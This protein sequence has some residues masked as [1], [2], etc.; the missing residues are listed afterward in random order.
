MKNSEGVVISTLEQASAAASGKF[1]YDPDTKA[2]TF[3]GI[4]DGTEIVVPYKRKIHANVLTNESDVY[5][6][7]C[8]LYIDAFA[9]DKCARVYRVQ[10]YIPKADF[11]G[12]FTF[13]M[14]DS[15]IVHSFEAEAQSGSCG[16]G[17]QLWTYTIF[18]V[19]EADVTGD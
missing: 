6:S 13:E 3:S 17:G 8:A 7:K 18:G 5:S 14:S 15:Q 16:T 11:N 10:F 19:D 9:E 12:E 1:A 4:A 2:L